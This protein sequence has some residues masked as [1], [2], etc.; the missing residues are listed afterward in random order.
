LQG[1]TLLL[2]RDAVEGEQVRDV[3]ALGA[4]PAGLQPAHLRTRCRDDVSGILESDPLG[5]TQTAKLAAQHDAKRGRAADA[6]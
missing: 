6:R 2:V 4:D 1:L 5:L 3:P